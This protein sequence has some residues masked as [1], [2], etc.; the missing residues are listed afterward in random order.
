M[1]YMHITYNK[2]QAL[3][4]Y[5][6]TVFETYNIIFLFKDIDDDFLCDVCLQPFVDP[7]DTRCGHTFCCV[8]LKNYV[9]LKKSCPIDRKQLAFL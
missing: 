8:C 2:L 1:T 5:E 4:N 7:Y 3:Q 6:Y 9:R